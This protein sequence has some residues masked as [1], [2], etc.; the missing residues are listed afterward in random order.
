[1]KLTVLQLINILECWEDTALLELVPIRGTDKVQVCLK[2]M[3]ML[4]Y[5][6]YTGLWRDV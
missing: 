3:P 5:D 4:E 1:M 2:G 6:G